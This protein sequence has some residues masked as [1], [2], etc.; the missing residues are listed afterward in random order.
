MIRIAIAALL[1]T[2]IAHGQAGADLLAVL[3]KA[4]NLCLTGLTVTG[5]RLRASGDPDFPPKRVRW[6]LSA[7]DGKIGYEE[8]I[9]EYVDW[10][11]IPG[12]EQLKSM[13]RIS[14]E[15][16]PNYRVSY[17]WTPDCI[18]SHNYIGPVHPDVSL[19][20]VN[21]DAE[22]D[23]ASIRI[24]PDEEYVSAPFAV[25]LPAGLPAGLL[26]AGY[27]GK[28]RAALWVLGRGYTQLIHEITEVE[29]LPDGT[30][31]AVAKGQ[32]FTP[33][34]VELTVD[35]AAAHL[36]RAARITNEEGGLMW[37]FHTEGTRVVGGRSVAERATET[38]SPGGMDA[39][40]Y[41]VTVTSV[42]AEADMAFL[43]RLDSADQPPFEV[44]T[45]VWDERQGTSLSYEPGQKVDR[46]TARAA[47]RL[48]R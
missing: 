37:E 45:D 26:A 43:N 7:V 28:I 20:E 21:A 42:S 4:D 35:P 10:S 33:V 27:K 25:E 1:C 38:S 8:T 23:C 15:L 41:P 19:R 3:Q 48:S 5:T 31:R 11:E 47:A 9:V 40:E 44:W 6:K 12:G 14:D 34:T 36:V 2:P 22:I 13:G 29:T 30:L 16:R 46:Q 32:H 17:L 39:L 18:K 24:V